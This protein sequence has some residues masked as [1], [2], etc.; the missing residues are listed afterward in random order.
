MRIIA[1]FTSGLV[2]AFFVAELQ[3][4]VRRK[5]TLIQ[6]FPHIHHSFVGII[7]LLAGF[8][9][10]FFGKSILGESLSILLTTFLLGSSLGVLVHHLLNEGFVISEKVERSF[11][12]RHETLIER[13]LEILPGSLTWLALTSPIWLSFTLPFAVAYIILIADVYWL[14]TAIRIAVLITIGYRKMRAAEKVDWLK[15]LE[16]NFP[17][18]WENY[19][20]LIVLPTANE[21]LEVLQPAFQAV[22]DS[23]YP[24][25]KIFLAVGFEERIQQKDPAGIAAKITRLQE[26]AGQIGG[27]FT[28]VHPFG[29]PGEVV[30][31]GTNRNW[32]VRNT[33]KE[34]KKRGI[35]MDKV[36][37]TTLDADFVIHRQFLAGALHK[38]LSTP[39]KIR[40]QRSFTGVFLYYNNYWDCPAFT[41][42]ISTG[43]AFWQIS[44]MVGSD[45]YINFSSLSMN[46]QS[47]LDM[48]LWIPNKVNDDS[49]FYWKAY[50]HF[51]GDYKVIPHFL[52]ILADTVLD[53]NLPKTLQ[54]QYLQLKRW[55]YGV[56]H[57]PFII[58][59]YFASKDLDFWDKTDK[60]LFILWSYMK[61]GT[62][63]LFI[64]F[65]G[66]LVPLINSD[67]S[68]SV[69]AYNLP[70]ISS[71]LLTAAFL[72]LFSTIFVHEKTVP[73]RPKN[74]SILQ[75]IWSFLQWALIPIILV[76]IASIPAIEAQ[77]RL[78]LGKYLEF[79]V[80]T[81]TRV[82]S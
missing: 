14:F 18:V 28:T 2:L 21:S 70:V 61:W 32:I 9:S 19:Y 12:Q 74:W 59:Q 23:T 55:A 81:K 82:A 79:R 4:R 73:P 50:Y 31:P 49:G 53:V 1:L 25:A 80:T 35:A 45:K 75:K 65:A 10:F 77:T 69:V 38:Y 47:L 29:L 11:V 52:P 34:F 39:A 26:L 33:V 30:G 42:L 72:G 27:V 57:I 22:V 7:L 3:V 16:Q 46:M 17:D 5:S 48:G 51:K 44:E 60:L 6:S 54:N 68:K 43:T 56:E 36:F 78:M 62:L 15:R 64:T 20:H 24:K 41:R 71:Y 66:L 37:V 76:T 40:N 58:R 67:Y 8:L 63:A 13:L